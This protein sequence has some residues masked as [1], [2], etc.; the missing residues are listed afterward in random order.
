MFIIIVNWCGFQFNLKWSFYSIIMLH[1]T[2]WSSGWG[3]RKIHRWNSSFCCWAGSSKY[4]F[5]LLII[6]FFRRKIILKLLFNFFTELNITVCRLNC[7]R[8]NYRIIIFLWVRVMSRLVIKFLLFKTIS[9]PKFIRSG[10]T[11]IFLLNSMYAILF[12]TN[13]PLFLAFAF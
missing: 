5:S 2:I 8:M 13:K 11:I 4:S 10:W 3:S 6:W 1:T 7:F 9:I 12:I